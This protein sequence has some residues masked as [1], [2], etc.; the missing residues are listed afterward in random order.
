MLAE[1]LS[2]SRNFSLL[3]GPDC[4][5]VTDLQGFTCPKGTTD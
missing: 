3:T 5:R 2:P 1:T 4:L